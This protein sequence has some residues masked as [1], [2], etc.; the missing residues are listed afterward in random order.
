M[1]VVVRVAGIAP[2]RMDLT[3]AGTPQP[4]RHEQVYL[5]FAV[6]ARAV[7]EQWAPIGGRAR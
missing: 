1:N 5:R 2:V 7:A 4:A 6:A 3:H